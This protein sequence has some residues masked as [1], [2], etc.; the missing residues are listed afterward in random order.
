MEFNAETIGAITGLLGF[1]F[2]MI[3]KKS[4]ADKRLENRF[5]IIE[6]QLEML[7]NDINGIALVLG[8]KRAIAEKLEKEKV[9]EE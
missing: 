3:S 8:T 9:T 1:I 2:G 5:T 4:K 6:T 7:M